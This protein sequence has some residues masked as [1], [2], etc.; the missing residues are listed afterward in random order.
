MLVGGGILLY[1][2]AEWLVGGAAGLARSIG[3]SSLLVGLTV[4][5][6]GTS[7]PEVIVGISAASNG[8]GEIALGNV[9]G[10]N[11]ANIALILGLTALIQPTPV[12]GA[13]QRREVPVLIA[14]AVI[15]PLVLLDGHLQGWE[16]WALIAGAL[17]YTLWMVATSRLEMKVAA[18]QAAVATAEAADLAGAPSTQ[19]SKLRLG[20]LALVGLLVLIIGGQLLVEG[21]TGIAR[22]IGISE[23]I[24]GLTIVAVGT[25]LPELATSLIAAYRGHAEIAVGNVVGSNIFNALLCLGSAGLAGSIGVPISSIALDLGMMVGLTL[26]GAFLLRTERRITR[27]EGGVLVALYLGFLAAVVLLPATS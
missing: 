23:R 15:V 6:Y 19:G 17:G 1:F 10:S 5:A 7:M 18:Q 8:H 27:V 26:V 14:T 24:V 2:G 13:L 3:V 21:A 20:A 4:V 11:I 25:S 16:A 9:L 12:S 22:A